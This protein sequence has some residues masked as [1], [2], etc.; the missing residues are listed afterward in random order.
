MT[1]SEV[2]NWA[3]SE[4]L[5][6]PAAP[7]MRTRTRSASSRGSWSRHGLL[8]RLW[9]DRGEVLKLEA[10]PRSLLRREPG[11]L[12]PGL[13]WRDAGRELPRD[14]SAEL[15]PDLGVRP[16]VLECESPDWPEPRE[17]MLVLE[18][19]LLWMESP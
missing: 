8:H 15:R 16:G 2:T 4:D 11:Q 1:Y 9:A 12:G 5:P 18:P 17:E 14:E 3:D 19:R 13:D 10:Y 7:R 6:T